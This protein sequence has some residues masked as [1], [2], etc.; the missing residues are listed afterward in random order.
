MTTAELVRHAAVSFANGDLSAEPR[1]NSFALP[2]EIP[3]QIERIYNGVYLLATLKRDEMVREER[4][5]KLEEFIREARESKKNFIKT[6][7]E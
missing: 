5:K 2:P 1:G 6:A 3:A 4:Q 7:S